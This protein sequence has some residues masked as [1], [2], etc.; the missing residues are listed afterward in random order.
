MFIPK[1]NKKGKI[2]WECIKSIDAANPN[3]KPGWRQ[4]NAKLIWSVC[5][6]DI[7]E[8]RFTEQQLQEYNVPKAFVSKI[9]K[10]GQQ[11]YT[12][13]A[14]IL[15][16]SPGVLVFVSIYDART[17]TK[18]A[19]KEHPENFLLWTSGNLGLNS[20]CELQARKVS[21]SSFGKINGKH[22]KLWNGKKI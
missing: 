15:K 20:Y 21:L 6:D 3:F 4:E 8:L 1:A 11:E 2:G 14:K 16:F 7:L 12:M 22:K 19:L 9:S 10:N 17:G 13:L 5:K 18:N